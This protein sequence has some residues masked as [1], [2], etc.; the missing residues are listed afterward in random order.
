MSFTPK[1]LRLLNVVRR[2]VPALRDESLWRLVLMQTGCHREG[3]VPKLS[4][5][6]NGHEAFETIMHRLAM[7]AESELD[8]REWEGKTVTAARRMRRALVA[9]HQQCVVRGLCDVA[10]LGGFCERMTRQRPVY[11]D[12]P[13]TRDVHRLEAWELMHVIEGFKAWMRREAKKAGMRCPKFS[14][15][16]GAA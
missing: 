11:M 2:R 4:H 1:Q 8:E 15:R 14:M 6:A 13:P 9:F 16:R 10:A 5:P 12:E 3:G 7:Y